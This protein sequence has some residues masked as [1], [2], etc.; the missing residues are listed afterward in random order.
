MQLP[1]VPQ[2]LLQALVAAA[3]GR[4]LALVGGAVRD[5]LLHRVHNDPWRGLPDLDLVVEGTAEEITADAADQRPALALAKA[6]RDHL[7]ADQVPSTC[8]HGRFGTVEVELRLPGAGTWLLDI[9]SARQERYPEPAENPVVRLGRL[10]DDLARRD[11][12]VNAIALL[13]DADGRGVHLLDPHGGQ[14]DLAARQLRLL[15]PG[16]LRDDPTRLLRGARYA[17]RLGFA[18]APESVAQAR[19]VIGAWPWPWRAGD[20]TGAA[21]PALGTRLRMELELLLEREPWPQALGDLQAWGGLAL[22]D[23]QLQVDATWRRRLHWAQRLGVPLPAALLAAAS[24]PLAVAERLQLPH[25][26]HRL[27][28]QFLELQQRFQRAGLLHAQAS[29]LSPAQWCALLEAPGLSPEAVALAVAADAAHRRPLLRWL[30]QWR[31]VKAPMTA[32]ELIAAGV[33]PGPELG[34]RL[35]RERAALLDAGWRDQARV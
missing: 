33:R 24:D 30:L 31:H 34:R 17:A 20:P 11:F 25:R 27:L 15:H 1:G 10:D 32:G 28:A 9:A 13:L 16:S 22:L 12:T 8:E 35:E 26:Q 14:A 19:E 21:P 7:G 4:R 18:L 23:V 29:P 6:L 5:L 3:G 2:E